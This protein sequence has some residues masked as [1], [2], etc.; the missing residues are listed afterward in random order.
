[1]LWLYRLTALLGMPLLIT[2]LKDPQSFMIHSLS[3]RQ[4]SNRCLR[5]RELR[6][7]PSVFW[8]ITNPE[9]PFN[10]HY[11]CKTHLQLYFKVICKNIFGARSSSWTSYQVFSP[12]AE[13]FG[14]EQSPYNHWCLKKK[15]WRSFFIRRLVKVFHS[16]SMKW[17]HNVFINAARNKVVWS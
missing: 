1:M 7:S 15:Q 14:A 4:S 10:E 17:L 9:L 5:S 8:L 2:P 13:H 3:A 16:S 6:R 11:S 12:F